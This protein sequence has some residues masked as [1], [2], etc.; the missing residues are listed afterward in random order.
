MRGGR[1]TKGE[2]NL[3]ILEWDPEPESPQVTKE[4][5]SELIPPWNLPHPSNLTIQQKK[6]IFLPAAKPAGQCFANV[7]L[8]GDHLVSGC[9]SGCVSFGGCVG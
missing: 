5:E 2:Y 9:A 3:P 7:L 8:V 6:S 4:P 1:Q